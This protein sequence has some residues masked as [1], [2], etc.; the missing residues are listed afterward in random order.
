MSE[1]EALVSWVVSIENLLRSV[2]A[3]LRR[4]DVLWVRGVHPGGDFV[5]GSARDNGTQGGI[6]YVGTDAITLEGVQAKHVL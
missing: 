1:N 6:R 2:S 4:C 3:A 5:N